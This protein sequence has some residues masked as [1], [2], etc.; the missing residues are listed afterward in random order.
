[1]RAFGDL[2]VQ[3]EIVSDGTG[4]PSV[5]D[6]E[7]LL[8]AV[9][10]L[11]EMGA[12][13]A[14]P[15]L[16]SP[17]VVDMGPFRLL[18]STACDTIRQALVVWATEVCP[19]L[20]APLKPGE[21]D[22][23]LLAC[24]DFDVD[25]N[26][27]LDFSLDPEGNLLPGSVA[28]D[29]CT[30]P[31]LVPDRLKQELFCLAMDVNDHG[32]LDP[33]ALDD[34]TDVN[35]PSPS[36]NDILVWQERDLPRGRKLKRWETTPHVLNNL[37]DVETSGVVDGHV[38]MYQG[39]QWVAAESPAGVSDRGNFVHAL[40]SSYAIVAAG[41][42]RPDGTP[43]KPDGITEGTSYNGLEAEPEGTGRYRLRFPLYGKLLDAGVTYIV[44]GTIVDPSL[45]SYEEY[46]ENLYEIRG[47]PFEYLYEPDKPVLN[48]YNLGFPSMTPATF[49]VVELGGDGI[50]VW[51]TQPRLRYGLFKA[52]AREEIDMGDDMNVILFTP[53]DKAFMVEISAYSPDLDWNW[54][55]YFSTYPD[56]VN[57]NTASIEELRSLPR[58]GPALAIRIVK[59]RDEVGGFTS[60]D[61]LKDVQ[62]I[63][64]FLVSRLRHL[65][66][67]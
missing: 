66:R 35:A 8:G 64:E 6:A 46:L 29:N 33:F 14:S 19:R 36:A 9:Q 59:L 49:Q 62:G 57:V 65:M 28:V 16:A 40:S 27:E 61:Q 67:L 31:V 5:D 45:S 13:L 51:I 4:S 3:V 60:L 34:L 25:V 30:R 11:V 63:D 20:H 43:V 17:P 55:E 44:K 41:Y 52:L 38:L 10:A 54:N 15:P 26:G 56:R 18:A 21:K 37:S 7:R 39:D 58:I 22:C 1:V 2:M 24:V 32:R 47:D 50:L 23:I 12:P 42:F 53:V 48:P